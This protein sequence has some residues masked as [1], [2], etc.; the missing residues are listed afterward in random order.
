MSPQ[1][2]AAAATAI[3]RSAMTVMLM[4]Q[5]G[6]SSISSTELLSCYQQ[7]QTG[8]TFST[9]VCLGKCAFK[10]S[11]AGAVLQRLPRGLPGLGD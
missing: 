10:I 2:S 3:V 9:G 7:L 11:Q 1:T 6:Q 5:A 4:F 8:T